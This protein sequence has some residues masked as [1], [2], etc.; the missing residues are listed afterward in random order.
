[1]LAGA[2]MCFTRACAR[3]VV[4]VVV[5]IPARAQCVATLAGWL[6]ALSPRLVLAALRVFRVR[7]VYERSLR[8]TA[9]TPQLERPHTDDDND[10]HQTTTTAVLAAFANGNDAAAAGLCGE[11]RHDTGHARECECNNIIL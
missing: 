8:R 4:G 11:I 2:N 1:M 7:T 5:V 6:L 9:V 10:D 3:V